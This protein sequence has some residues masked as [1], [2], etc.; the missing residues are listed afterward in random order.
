MVPVPGSSRHASAD[1]PHCTRP[2]RLGSR[3]VVVLC[4]RRSKHAFL[5]LSV[6]S[7][8]I[9]RSRSSFEARLSYLW[10]GWHRESRSHVGL[11]S[12]PR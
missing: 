2:A 7:L 10:V 5:S 1:R 9:T 8:Q 4:A 6:I 3:E 12:C 11:D